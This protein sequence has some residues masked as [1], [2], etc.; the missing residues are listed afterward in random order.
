MTIPNL[1]IIAGTGTK[2]GKTTLACKLI[3]QISDQQPVA[4]KITPHFHDNTPG[5]ELLSEGKGYEIYTET[6]PGTSKDTSR[7]LHAGASRVY[8]AKVNDETLFEAFTRIM[9]QID[10]TP[11]I[12]CESPALRYYV[13]P[14]MF[15]IMTSDVVDKHK[16][17]R[18][19]QTLPHVFLTLEEIRTGQTFP[20][21][22]INGKWI[23]KG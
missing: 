15:I 5:L 22:F 7:M 3:E 12:I 1:L 16:D 13:D 17:I 10:G 19:L 20:M 14:G 4:I 8:F 6:D 18:R 11:P 23:Y 9:E 21:N 2:S